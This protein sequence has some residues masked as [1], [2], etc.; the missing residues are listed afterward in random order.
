MK[1]KNLLYMY[2]INCLPLF[3][4][5][6]GF[7]GGAL[8]DFLCMP[9]LQLVLTGL[10]FRYSSNWGWLFLSEIHMWIMSIAGIVA[11][12]WLWYHLISSDSQTIFV[13]IVECRMDT[14]Y[15]AALSLIAVIAK[16]IYT[17]YILACQKKAS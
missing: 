9:V 4:C 5:I 1:K 11:S 14:V 17:G 7:I 6:V 8:F 15:M 16:L 13:G 10:N 3:F 2:V 12:T